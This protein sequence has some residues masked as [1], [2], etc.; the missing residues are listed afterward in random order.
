MLLPEGG[1]K[2]GCRQHVRCGEVAL[3]ETLDSPSVCR[4][5]EVTVLGKE[6]AGNRQC[7]SRAPGGRL[8]CPWWV[9]GSTR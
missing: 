5:W 4:A 2:M 7:V 1:R 8:V 9:P 3:L 6:M